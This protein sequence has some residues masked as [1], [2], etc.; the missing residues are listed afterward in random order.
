MLVSCWFCWKV[1]PSSMVKQ[2]M[3]STSSMLAAAIT[4]LGIPCM[5]SDKVMGDQVSVQS[6]LDHPVAPVLQ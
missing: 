2:E 6:H 3:A 4:R 1:M 5:C